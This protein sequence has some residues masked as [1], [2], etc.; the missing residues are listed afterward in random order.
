LST[1]AFALSPTSVFVLG[2][3]ATAATHAFLLSP[4]S[5][6]E[7]PLRIPRQHARGVRLATGQIA[8]IGWQKQME[9]FI[10]AP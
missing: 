6:T 4:S 5:M 10:P 2:D 9:S 7:E 1:Q 8:V 3:D